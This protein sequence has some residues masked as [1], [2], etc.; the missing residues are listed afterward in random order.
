MRGESD[1]AQFMK[2]F[3]L[4][5]TLL[6]ISLQYKLWFAPDGVHAIEHLKQQISEQVGKNTA[7]SE[8]NYRLRAE[9]L[10]LKQGVTEL[11]EHARTDLEM[12]KSDEHFYQIL[13]QDN[14]N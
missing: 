11:E 1:S 13:D 12:I 7:L 5:L 9:I 3:I 10:D 4:I 14:N 6:F 2:P 8:R